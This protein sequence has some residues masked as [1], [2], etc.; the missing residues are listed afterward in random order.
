MAAVPH[1][2][3]SQFMW[4]AGDHAYLVSVDNLEAPDVDIFDISNPRAP[5]KIA[6]YD[7]NT[8][9]GGI[10]PDGVSV[11]ASRSTTTSSSRRS[12]VAR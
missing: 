10:I 7:L 4:D 6:E 8:A 12:T 9:F 1:E 2:S 5:V 3:H 11:P